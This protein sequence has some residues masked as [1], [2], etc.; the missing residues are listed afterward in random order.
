MTPQGEY[1]YTLYT[2]P[3]KE[4]LVRDLLR[5]LEV[6]VYLPEV[7]VASPRRGRRDT[8]PFFPHYLFARFDLRDGVTAKIRYTPGVRRIV[9]AGGRPVPVAEEV[10]TYI[11]HRLAK[12]TQREP[13]GPFKK[14]EVV[15]IVRG[16]LKGLDAVF[17]ERLSPQGRV[18]V[19]LQLMDRLVATEMDL[20]DLLPPH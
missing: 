13:E 19:F 12:M 11:R 8:K 18:R 5:N 20:G 6:D 2:K 9:S 17:D 14:G 4:Y 1:W 15:R 10:V 16:P 3:H 7:R